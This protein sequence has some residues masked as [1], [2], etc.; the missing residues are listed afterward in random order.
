MLTFSGGWEFGN[1]FETQERFSDMA[2]SPENR[3]TFNNSLVSYIQKY[4]LDGLD[5]GKKLLVMLLILTCRYKV[6]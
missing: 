4:A 2:S 1:N 5:I 3:S 6:P